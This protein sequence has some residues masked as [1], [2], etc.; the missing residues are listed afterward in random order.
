M[1]K[2]KLPKNVKINWGVDFIKIEGPLGVIVKKKDAFF[3]AIKEEHLFLW[4]LDDKKENFY[5]TILNS[6]IIGVTK[7]FRQR[8][9]LIGVGFKAR[10]AENVVFFKIGYSHEIAY[11]IP[12][13][14]TIIISKNK[15]IFLLIKGKEKERVKQVAT[16]IRALRMPDSYKGKGIHFNKQVLKLKKGKR[17]GK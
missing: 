11:T 8:L 10:I 12:A 15:G 3:L 1:L 9:K 16:E 4:S 17:E 13:D 6:L 5:L 14:I 2:I 7:G